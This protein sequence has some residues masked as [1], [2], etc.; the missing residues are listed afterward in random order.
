MHAPDHVAA[1]RFEPNGVRRRRILAPKLILNIIVFGQI[2]VGGEWRF[3][4]LLLGL[5]AVR[6]PRRVRYVGLV[7]LSG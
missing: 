1:R 4:A 7:Q 6:R 3:G 5:P 2:V